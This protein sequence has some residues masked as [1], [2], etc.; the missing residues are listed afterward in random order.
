MERKGVRTEQPEMRPKKQRRVSH[1]C[2]CWHVKNFGYY[3]LNNKNLLKGFKHQC[4]W[5][6][7]GWRRDWRVYLGG[8]CREYTRLVF[9][10]E[11]EPG[12]EDREITSPEQSSLTQGLAEMPAGKTGKET[13]LSRDGVES[14]KKA[15]GEEPGSWG[16]IRKLR[17]VTFTIKQDRFPVE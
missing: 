15:E 2:F 5:G 3:P 4:S 10:T 17:W 8:V 7:G 16:T 13:E 9:R 14:A 1:A 6:A 11:F 12:D